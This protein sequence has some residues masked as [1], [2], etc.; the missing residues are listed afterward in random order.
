VAQVRWHEGREQSGLARKQSAVPGAGRGGGDECL[1]GRV[2]PGDRRRRRE[3]ATVNK[4]TA[5]CPAADSSGPV[6]RHVAK[7]LSVLEATSV[8]GADPALRI[9]VEDDIAGAWVRTL[10]RLMGAERADLPRGEMAAS[11]RSRY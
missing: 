7:A 11:A 2:R 4:V 8:P 1:R 5:T 3:E 6:I 10:R 9:R